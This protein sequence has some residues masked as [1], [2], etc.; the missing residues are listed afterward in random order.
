MAALCAGLVSELSPLRERES[1]VVREGGKSTSGLEPI[2]G[3]PIALALGALPPLP[4]CLFELSFLSFG[5]LLCARNLKVRL[6]L[7]DSVCVCVFACCVCVCVF[8]CVCVCAEIA[9]VD[10]GN[11]KCLQG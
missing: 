11:Q 9:L 10:N 7:Y 2:P 1:G 6:C 8:V 3:A 5:A 4:P